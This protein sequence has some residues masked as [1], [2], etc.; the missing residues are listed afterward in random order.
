M[1]FANMEDFAI[2]TLEG[3]NP[4]SRAELIDEIID[5]CDVVARA[6]GGFL[7]IGKVSQ[8]EA[9]V[10]DCVIRSLGRSE[11]SNLAVS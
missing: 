8:S 4:T 1:N 7:G 6:S 2:A 11:W 9:E 10:I 5:L 3:L